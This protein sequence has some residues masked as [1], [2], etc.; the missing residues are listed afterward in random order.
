MTLKKNRFKKCII[1]IV[2]KKII[3][4]KKMNNCDTRLSN[5]LFLKTNTLR[6]L[7]HKLIFNIT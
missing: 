5:F 4:E 1:L 2:I 6:K 7:C 3:L